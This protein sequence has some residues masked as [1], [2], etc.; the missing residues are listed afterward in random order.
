MPK[1]AARRR[2][3]RVPFWITMDFAWVRVVAILAIAFGITLFLQNRPRMGSIA[4]CIDRYDAAS[5]SRDSAQI[6][7]LR[8]YESKKM[9][10]QTCAVLRRSPAYARA[11]NERHP[12]PHPRA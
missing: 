3:K 7:S 11:L 2:N 9:R 10:G 5:T 12:Q 4:E 8:P 6:D 1:P